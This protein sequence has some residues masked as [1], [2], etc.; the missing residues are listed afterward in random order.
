MADI[1]ADVVLAGR[2]LADG[3][4]EDAVW[5]HV[6]IRDPDGRGVWMKGSGLGL[7][8]VTV[9]DVVLVDCQ[10]EV[11]DGSRRR[12]L[13]YPIHTETMRSRPDVDCVIHTHPR[14]ATAFGFTELALLPCSQATGLFL[15][16]VPRFTQTARLIDSPEMG[17]AVAET[18]GN[19]QAAFLVNHGVIV[20]GTN[21]AEATV[22]A[23]ALE[24]ACEEQLLAAAAGGRAYWR[25]PEQAAEDYGHVRGD[26]YVRTTWEYLGRRVRERWR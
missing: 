6:S 13:E 25:S 14:H 3:G 5:G 1:R 9:D 22:A 4:H 19:R 16:G 15:D 10:G 2:I 21:V 8:E 18:L 24:R 20:V 17:R 12:H 23:I 7:G 11:L 26:A